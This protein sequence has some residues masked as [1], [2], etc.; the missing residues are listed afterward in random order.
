MCNLKMTLNGKK[1]CLNQCKIDTGANGNLLPVSM[2]KQLGGIMTELRETIGKSVRLVAYNDTEI[3]QYGMCHIDLQFKSGRK[4]AKF[5][6]L[7]QCTTLIGLTDSIKLSLIT[8][9]CFDSVSNTGDIDTEIKSCD[10]PEY[11]SGIAEA[12]CQNKVSSYQFKTAI[13]DEYK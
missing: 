1:T 13:L 12:K 8:V 7:D 5:F 10:S 9:N 2:F 3:R 11:F 6:V 4:T